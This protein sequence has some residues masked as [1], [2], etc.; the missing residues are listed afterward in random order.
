M[1]RSY[2]LENI[3]DSAKEF[4]RTFLCP[5]DREIQQLKVGDLVR[6]IFVFDIRT[7]D[8]WRGERMWVEISEITGKKYKGFLTNQPVYIKELNLGDSVAFGAENIATVLTELKFNEDL[9]AIISKKALEK[10]QIN[11]MLREDTSRAEDSG[12]QFYYGDE[13]QDYLDIVDN[14]KIITLKE[15]LSFESRIEKVLKSTH[16]AFEWSEKEN[17]FIEAYF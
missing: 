16:H 17:D 1:E 2:H 15:V 6:L 9:K 11:W 3:I 14:C 8:N 10:K 7:E 13:D 12:W 5:S 4:P